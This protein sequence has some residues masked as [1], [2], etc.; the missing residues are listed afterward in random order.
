MIPLLLIFIG[1]GSVLLAMAVVPSEQRGWGKLSKSG[2][3]LL[4]LVVACA[5]YIAV[6]AYRQNSCS[7]PI[8]SKEDAIARAKDIGARWDRFHF[9]EIGDSHRF[10]S[11]LA[12]PDCCSA[13]REFDSSR[14]TYVWWVSFGIRPSYP[15]Y[16]WPGERARPQHAYEADLRITRCGWVTW[17]G[18]IKHVP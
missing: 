3:V 9:R 11:E 17:S 18:T 13:T 5:G 4:I 7:S 14:L 16:V 8:V 12:E 10:V 1:V 2:I 15:T 6:F